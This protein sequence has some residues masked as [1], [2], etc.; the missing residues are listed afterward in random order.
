MLLIVAIFAYEFFFA[1][2]IFFASLKMVGNICLSRGKVHSW[3]SDKER[4]LETW[5]NR[6][7]NMMDFIL[8]RERVTFRIREQT[9]AEKLLLYVAHYLGQEC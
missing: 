7:E 8:G 6:V 1:V 5:R 2:V 9:L 4:A 3:G